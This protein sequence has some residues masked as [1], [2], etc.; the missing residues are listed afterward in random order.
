MIESAQQGLGTRLMRGAG[1]TT[2]GFVAAQAL[3]FGSNLL[4]AR[5]L[6]PEAFG[7]MALVTVFLVGAVMMSDAGIGQ[8]VRQSP[9]GDD[10]LF[11]HT[12]YSLQVLRGAG[13]WLVLSLL[14]WPAAKF[15]NVPD[16]ALMLPVAGVTLLLA[17]LEPMKAELAYRHL[18]VGRVTLLDLCSQ[19]IGIATMVGLAWATRSVW[20]LVLGMV[21][22]S[23]VKTTLYWVALPGAASRFGWDRSAVS[24]LYRFGIWIFMSSAFGFMLSQG[25]KAIFGRFLSLTDLGI[26]NLAFFLASFPSLLAGTLIGSLM[27]PAYRIARENGP[28]AVARLRRMR[29]GLSAVILLALALLALIGPWIVGLLYDGRYAPAG[30]VLVWI[31]LMQMW[32]MIGLS[33]DQAALAAGDSRSF[34]WVIALRA[35]AQTVL[36]VAGMVWG[37]MAGALAGQALASVLVHPAIIWI[38]RKHGVWDPSHDLAAAL[39]AGVF[40]ATMIFG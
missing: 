3:R 28:V 26:Y 37:G 36:F 14:A 2:L 4:L 32:P 33:Y 35:L 5:L 23:F 24:D 40:G 34:F 7:V 9:R 21:V 15:Y 20:A 18:A 17:G 31:A 1:V 10:P 27:L 30:Q 19:G 6:F 25:D 29:Y 12:A 11:L 22:T 16:L 13:L 38:A 8:S 39:F